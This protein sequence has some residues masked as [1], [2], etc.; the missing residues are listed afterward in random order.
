MDEYTP[1]TDH[2]SRGIIAQATHISEQQFP[3]PNRGGTIGSNTTEFRTVVLAALLH[4][5]GKFLQRGSFPWLKDRVKHPARSG[6]FVGAFQSLFADVA[7]GSLLRV[8]VEHHHEH[9][10]FG[11]LCVQQ[12]NGDHERALAY[13]VSEA[14]NLSSAERGE[15]AEEY[16]DYKTTPLAPVFGRIKLQGREKATALRY[17]ARP[18]GGP[19]TLDVIFPEVLTEFA[20]GEMNSLLKAFGEE[21]NRLSKEVKKTDFDCLL[22]HLM[23]ILQ[24]HMWCVPSNTQEPQPDVSLYDHLKTTSAIAACLYR[25]HEAR[26]TLD[27]KHIKTSAKKFLMVVGDLSGIQNY[28][29]DIATA[30]VGGVARRLRSR[31]LFIQLITEVA[32]HRIL[33]DLALPPT[34]M[35]MQS[36]G[37][38]YLLL[39]NLKETEE[40]VKR[41]QREV[42]EW[43]LKELGGEIALNLA[44]VEFGHDGFKSEGSK[45]AGFGWVLGEINSRL[46]ARK[47]QP[48]K[49]ALQN[50]GAWKEHDF[51]RPTSFEGKQPC[52][53]CHRSPGQVGEAPELLC[54][55]CHRDMKWGREIPSAKYIAF[56]AN[57]TTGDLSVLGYSASLWPKPVSGAS[58]YLVLKLNDFDM[59]DL[60]GFP[61]LPRYLANHIP[62]AN[63]FECETCRLSDTC[64]ERHDRGETDPATFRCLAAYSNG[65]PLLGF[66]KA[67]VDNL[68]KVFTFGLKRD[69]QDSDGR[70]YD[71]ISRLTTLSRLLDTFFSGWVEH[72]TQGE[73][74]HCYTIFSGGD[75]LFLVGPWDEILRLAERVRDDFAHYVGNPEITLSA[76]TFMNKDR[77]PVSRAAAEVDDAVEEAKQSGRNAVTVLGQALPWS[78]WPRARDEWRRLA[79]TQED[80]SSRF[81]HNLLLYAE[82]W[83]DYKKRGNVLGLRFQPL[84]AYDVGRNVDRKKSPQLSSWSDKLL[85]IPIDAEA[86]TVLNNLKLSTTPV[87][88]THLRAHE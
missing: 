45:G 11:D 70:S 47:R 36:G 28:I 4:D 52:A 3:A 17:H 26:N 12:V 23:G 64:E 48:F 81:L 62:R 25:Y 38:F 87:S 32:A 18:L 65:R 31:S 66:L 63:D 54:E 8:L 68:G 86:E 44:T 80:V 59:R 24:K 35:V 77:F 67:D 14:D 21:F 20:P 83:Q 9:P 22:T 42:D 6:E 82:M 71:T 88:Y 40:T 60:Y 85:R 53:S 73:F 74:R 5:I 15:A 16:Q 2:L 37:K 10:S 58:P 61:A 76:G 1:F 34:N 79:D 56:F 13:L 39:P 84:L 27:E 78:E 46:Q 57:E 72:L 50:S 19:A 30:G 43:L 75:D 51:L 69:Q 55:R 7:D 29:F 49:E 41:V 33:R